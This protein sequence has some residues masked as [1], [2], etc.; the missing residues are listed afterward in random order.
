MY[1]TKKKTQDGFNTLLSI[2][3]G[4]LVPSHQISQQTP[5]HISYMG[6]PSYI[7]DQQSNLVV[8]GGR[9]SINIIINRN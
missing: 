4:W 1:L 8:M 2:G 7:S 5:T 3:D 9:E 6:T